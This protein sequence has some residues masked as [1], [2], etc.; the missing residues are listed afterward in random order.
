M[1][2][3]APTRSIINEKN[4]RVKNRCLLVLLLMVVDCLAETAAV[5]D[6]P[7]EMFMIID[8]IVIVLCFIIKFI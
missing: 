6:V 7:I 8:L 5:V 3:D 1:F 2:T 4:H